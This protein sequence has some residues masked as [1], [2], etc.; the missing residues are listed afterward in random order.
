MVSLREYVV[1]QTSL[2]GMPEVL[3]CWWATCGDANGL[4]ITEIPR[5]MGSLRQ[6][7]PCVVT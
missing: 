6:R 7:V 1:S 2:V 5:Y 3:A 4:Q